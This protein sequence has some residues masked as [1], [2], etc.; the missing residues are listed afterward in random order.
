MQR[1]IVA[2]ALALSACT[3]APPSATENAAVAE[4]TV[5]QEPSEP[6][7]MATN[8]TAP[9]PTTPLPAPGRPSIAASPCDFQDG[10]VLPTTRLRGTGTEPFWSTRIQGRCV[11]YSTPENQAGT[12]VWTKFAGT[13][14][15]GTWS[16]M[17][18]GRPFVLKTKPD[19]KCSDGM[20]DTVYP[21]AVSLTVGGEQRSGCARPE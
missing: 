16:G 2:A 19:A 14:E 3:Q 1:T 12:R 9:A 18:D 4:V 21:I 11:T 8:A 20:S 5:N 17:L 10:K 6:P 13:G 7:E 15:S